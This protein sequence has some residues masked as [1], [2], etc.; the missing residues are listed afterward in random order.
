MEKKQFDS[1]AA[2]LNSINE[3]L[4]ILI[5]LQKQ[6]LP[7]PNIGGEEKKVL[8]FCDKKHTNADIVTLTHKT[9]TNVDS[10]L[11]HLRDMCN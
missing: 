4:D 1:L 5:N 10:I 11:S 3:K 6:T 7:K 9:K 8:Q 2:S